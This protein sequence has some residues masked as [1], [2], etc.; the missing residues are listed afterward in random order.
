[1]QKEICFSMST[2]AQESRPGH[3]LTEHPGARTA[4]GTGTNERESAMTP[5]SAA[6]RWRELQAEAD[7]PEVQEII[8][9]EISKGTIRVTPGPDGGNRIIPC[10]T[11]DRLHPVALPVRQVRPNGFHLQRPVMSGGIPGSPIE[12]RSHI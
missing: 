2:A 7:Q 3:P 11:E 9:Q 1:M 4:P 12:S 5:R 8:R 6:I 10:G